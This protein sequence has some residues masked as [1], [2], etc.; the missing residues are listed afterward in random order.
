MRLRLATL[1]PTRLSRHHLR[2]DLP[3][4]QELHILVRP[5][6]WLSSTGLAGLRSELESVTDRSLPARPSYGIYLPDDRVFDNRVISLIRPAGGGSVLAF[7]AMVLL[8]VVAKGRPRRVVHLGLVVTGPDCRQ[9]GLMRTLYFA[10]MV[11]LWRLNGFRRMWVTS[12]SSVPAIV[13]AVADSYGSVFPHYLHP[14]RRPSQ[15]QLEIVRELVRHHAHEFG[16]GPG[17]FADLERFV[18]CNSFCGGSQVLM[19]APGHD[20]PYRDPRC[21][22]FCDRQLDRARGDE[23]IQI[24]LVSFAEVARRVPAELLGRPLRALRARLAAS[25]GGPRAHGASR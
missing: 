25:A 4:R 8:D 19:A 16:S 3:G 18:L 21:E 7:A 23:F 9:A 10:P 14:G 15:L 6:R 12:V 22:A 20:A 11:Q 2:A 1:F 13:G 17:T 24:G 5:Y